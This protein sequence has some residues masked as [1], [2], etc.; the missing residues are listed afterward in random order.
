MIRH[1]AHADEETWTDV[2]EWNEI[3]FR[4]E[5]VHEALRFS[6]EMSFFFRVN[7]KSGDDS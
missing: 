2:G 4:N 3:E 6:D 5:W 7:K 1:P